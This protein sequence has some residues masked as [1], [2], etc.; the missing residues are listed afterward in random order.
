MGDVPRLVSAPLLPELAIPGLERIPVVGRVLFEQSIMF[1]ITLALAVVAGLVLFRTRFGL[2]LRAVGENPAA[3]AASGIDVARMRI[4]GVL[5]SGLRSGLAGAY[6][7]LVQIG[8][9]RD[10][11]V[12]GRGFIALGIVILG[13][14][15]PYLAI[16]AA[17]GFA[18][19]D[20]LPLSLQLLD[21]D[22][23]PQ[24]LIALPYVL[25]V[26]AVSGLLGRAR[27]PAALMVPY[28][29]GK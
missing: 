9:F 12:S 17:F 13:R 5:V 23:P 14:W 15:N 1:Y 19:M 20:A 3:A 8:L 27:N 11:I 16:A 21:L 6:F 18:A 25:T 24:F 4:I 28:D 29:D 22:I 10:T 2:N 7:V 26:I